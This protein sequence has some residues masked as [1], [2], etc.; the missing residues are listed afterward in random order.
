MSW[1]PRKLQEGV[2]EEEEELSPLAPQQSGEQSAHNLQEALLGK[3]D[4]G[5]GGLKGG[6]PSIQSW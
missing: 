2:R 3:G 1:R 4:E 6:L 5:R